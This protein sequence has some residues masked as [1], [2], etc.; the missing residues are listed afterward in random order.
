MPLFHPEVDILRQREGNL[1][2]GEKRFVDKHLQ[3]CA[4]CREY[5]AFVED[6]QAGLRELTP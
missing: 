6:F 5:L 1:D 2:E 4:E 3:G